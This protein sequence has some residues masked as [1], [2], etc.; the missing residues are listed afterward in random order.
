[1]AAGHLNKERMCLEIQRCYLERS[2]VFPKGHIFYFIPCQSK[3]GQEKKFNHQGDRVKGI[4]I[5][6]VTLWS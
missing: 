5:F 2:L 3:E 4:S 1:M 6:I